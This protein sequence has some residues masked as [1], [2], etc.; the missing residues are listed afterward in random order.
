MTGQ[1]SPTTTFNVRVTPR[2]RQNKVQRQADGS[3]KVYVTAPPEDGRANEAV[4]ETIAE[5]L[6][7]KRR[8]VEIVHGATSR[9]KIVRVAGAVDPPV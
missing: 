6:G 3:L 8:D 5:W 1:P 9:N 4:V 2:A 7:V